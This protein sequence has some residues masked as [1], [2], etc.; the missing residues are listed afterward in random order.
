MESFEEAY[1][2][3]PPWETGRPQGVFR[4]I[5]ARGGI[6]GDVL[7][8]G[9]GTGENAIYIASRG[10]RVLGVD[11]VE[12]AIERA[13]EKA[14]ERGV[15]ATFM[16]GDAMDSPGIG[17]TFETVIDSGL[18]H[19]FGDDE[20]ACFVAGLRRLVHPGGTYY[21]LCFS[22][23]E[24]RPEGPRRVSEQEIRDAFSDG[25]TVRSIVPARYESLVHE[26]GARAWL[27]TIARDETEP[28]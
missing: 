11:K 7:D 25:W 27:A 4:E 1:R 19:V 15:D 23:R 16:V 20:R 26:G 10:H 28:H 22:D 21:M 17:R 24:T 12:T 13:R 5:A 8:L 9:C 3:T 14:R 2:G 18:F 6:R